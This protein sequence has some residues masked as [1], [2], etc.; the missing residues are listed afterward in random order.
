M[1]RIVSFVHSPSHGL[2]KSYS[3]DL[4]M[5]TWLLSINSTSAGL[6]RNTIN[7]GPIQ[8]LATESKSYVT[9][10]SKMVRKTSDIENINALNCKVS[11]NEPT[12]EWMNEWINGKKRAAVAKHSDVIKCSFFVVLISFDSDT[13]RF[14]ARRMASTRAHS[15]I[16]SRSR[17]VG[18]S[19]RTTYRIF[20]WINRNWKIWTKNGK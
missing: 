16:V 11:T 6:N 2:K 15:A 14:T 18:S 5:Y 3:A 20:I 13:D 1:R 10:F 19:A 12:N 9:L 17:V 7:F 4:S 8:S